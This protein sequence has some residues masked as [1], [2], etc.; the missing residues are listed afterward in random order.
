MLSNNGIDVW[1]SFSRWVPHQLAGRQT[2]LV[3][4]LLILPV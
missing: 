2:A 3:A 1:D 4:Y